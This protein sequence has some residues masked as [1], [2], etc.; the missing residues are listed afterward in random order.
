MN[1]MRDTADKRNFI[2]TLYYLNDTHTDPN[3]RRETA[4]L[5]MFEHPASWPEREPLAHVLAWTLLSNHFHMIVEESREG[6][7][8]KLMQRIS[9]SLS[10]S[11]NLKY[12]EKGSLFQG[13]Y[14]GK[15]IDTDTHL[16]YLVF[17]VLIKNVLDM[18]PGGLAAAQRNFDDA[19]KWATQYPYSS[20]RDTVFGTMSPLLDDGGRII[21]DLIGSG[22]SYKK[23]AREL[24]DFHITA[25]GKDFKDVMLEAW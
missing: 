22:D 19:W 8:A 25:H 7:T 1:I 9:G 10:M 3:W 23:E 18:Y 11:F 17:Y 24:L 15:T 14:H 16:S 6:G 12:K 2:R 21:A 13:G 20:F 4:S 5:D